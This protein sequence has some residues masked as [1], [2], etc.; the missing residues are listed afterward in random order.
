MPSAAHEEAASG[1]HASGTHGIER[2]GLASVSDTRRAKQPA[3]GSQAP[4]M[5]RSSQACSRALAWTERRGACSTSRT[6]A[7][8][9]LPSTSIASPSCNMPGTIACEAD[10]LAARGAAMG[11]VGQRG[12][13]ETHA[14]C[15]VVGEAG[16]QAISVHGAPGAEAGAGPLMRCADARRDAM[17]PKGRV[18]CDANWLGLSPAT[19][20]IHSRSTCQS[21]SSVGEAGEASRSRS[22]RRGCAW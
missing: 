1:P 15:V 18:R 14:A 4:S 16:E 17:W 12:R 11:R 7:R 22:S 10:A 21:V 6:L 20:T 8:Q 9:R 3:W 2:G 5:R 13:A 19:S